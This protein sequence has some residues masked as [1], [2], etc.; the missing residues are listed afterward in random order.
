MGVF[1][2]YSS[3]DL[4]ATT[5][6]VANL[7]KAGVDS[8]VA[9]RDMEEGLFARHIAREIAR[10]D[11]VV[12]VV[13]AATEESKWVEQELHFAHANA[14]LLIPYIIGTPRSDGWLQLLIGPYDWI[15]ARTDDKDGLKRLAARVAPERR[16]GSV[17][18]FLNMKGGVGK[19]TL[20][21]NLGAAANIAHKQSI[22]YLDLDPQHN[23]TQYFLAEPQIDSLRSNE[24]TILAL[25]NARGASQEYIASV[26]ERRFALNSPNGAV[27]MSPAID[28]LAGHDDLFEFALDLRAEI[29]RS[30]ALANFSAFVALCRQKYDAVIIDV[31]PS[32][33][34]L[35][36]C[37]LS[38]ADHIVAPVRPERYSL[39]GLIMLRRLI[40]KVRGREPKAA[41]LSIIINVVNSRFGAAQA[42]TIASTRAKIEEF[43]FFASALL[44]D[45]IPFS[46]TL[47]AGLDETAVL[48]PL[49]NVAMRSGAKAALKQALA[50]AW[51]SVQAR[52][53][54]VR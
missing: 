15:D 31:N 35:T 52:A 48:T 47:S 19:T 37:A 24:R 32:A 3:K 2:S 34:F 49:H 28:L 42:N 26:W 25:F 20:A 51:T 29:D 38:V 44:K 5:Y 13:S 30:S 23:L 41:D 54:A 46:T 40:E 53:E 43:D 11:A 50:N 16:T 7:K 27:G 21:A 36:K 9:E 45:E 33:S 10:A 17:L 4:A 6:L 39:N 8:W 1:V 12:V 22:F 18:T 14:K